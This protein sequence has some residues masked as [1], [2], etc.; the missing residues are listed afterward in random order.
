[1]PKLSHLTVVARRLDPLLDALHSA[2]PWRIAP[3]ATMTTWLFSLTW[4][5]LNMCD[6]VCESLCS[7]K[8]RLLSTLLT[9]P[10]EGAEARCSISRQIRQSVPQVMH[11][12]LFATDLA[13]RMPP[14]IRKEIPTIGSYPHDARQVLIYAW[15][16]RA[17][18]IWA[19]DFGPRYL[20]AG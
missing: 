20:S 6:F 18:V 16:T 17:A 9:A 13:R 7:D 14:S 10:D 8:P 11:R 12:L 3:P 5:E 19:Q 15:R 1:M 4:G 2:T